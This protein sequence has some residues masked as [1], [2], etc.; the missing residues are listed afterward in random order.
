MKIGCL[1]TKSVPSAL[2]RYVLLAGVTSQRQAVSSQ[3]GPAATCQPG[4]AISI[5]RPRL[6]GVGN[7]PICD[8]ATSN[9]GEDFYGTREG[10]SKREIIPRAQALSPAISTDLPHDKGSTCRDRES[11]QMWDEGGAV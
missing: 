6:V 2:I 7:P 5:A 3:N 9:E 10:R 4:F 1:A 11:V 8:M